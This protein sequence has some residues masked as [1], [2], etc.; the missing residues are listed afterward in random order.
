[1]NFLVDKDK[2]LLSYPKKN[3]FWNKVRIPENERDNQ[4]IIKLVKDLK[5][6]MEILENQLIDKNFI[7]GDNFTM[8]DIPV[9][10]SMFKGFE[11]FL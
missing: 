4:K 10:A 7:L 8:G 2:E 6:T 5:P 9:G 3:E 11:I 1:M